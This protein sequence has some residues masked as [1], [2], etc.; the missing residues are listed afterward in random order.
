MGISIARWLSSSMWDFLFFVFSTQSPSSY[1]IP[2]IVLYP[3]LALMYCVKVYRFEITK[4]WNNCL[5]CHRGCAWWEHSCVM[6]MKHSLTIW[7]CRDELSLAMLFWED[8]IALISMLEVLLFLMS[9][10]TFIFN[11]LDLNIHATI[12]KITLWI[13]LGIIPH[14]KFSFYQLPTRGRAGIKLGDAWYVSNVSIIFDCS[15]LLYLLFWTILGFISTFIL[16]LGLT[17]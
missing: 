5:A 6:K 10:W 11:H 4:V 2:P 17:Y 14:Q 3:W 1:S 15:M 9:I 16:F 13:M 12:K 8:T 7:F